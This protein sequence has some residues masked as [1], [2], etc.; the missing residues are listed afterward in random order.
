MNDSI[1]TLVVIGAGQLGSRHLQALAKIDFPANIQVVDPNQTSL[2]VAEE[3]YSEI[4]KN[5]LINEISFL[6]SIDELADEIDFCVIA[7]NADVRLRVL[8]DLLANKSIRFLLLEKVLFQSLEELN[9]AQILLRPLEGRVWVNC[10]RRM[11][12]VYQE[13]KKYFVGKGPIHYQLIGSDWGLACNGIHFLDHL[14]WLVE[15]SLKELDITGLDA[16]IHETKR[17]GFVEFTGVLQGIYENGSRISLISIPNQQ[18][19]FIKIY[20]ENMQLEVREGDGIAL[21]RQK[22]KQWEE[23]K[24]RFQ[25]PFQSELTQLVAKEVLFKGTCPLTSFKESSVLHG[26]FLQAVKQ[27]LERVS[28]TRYERCPIT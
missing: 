12:S 19:D 22:N 8:K 28:G 16:I 25:N 13:L 1:R 5:S 9:E 2:Q 11:F 15:D 23:E 21:L 17:P 4:A 20:T 6:G 18:V 27:H 7:T 26:F 14:A 10:P 24:I 3:R